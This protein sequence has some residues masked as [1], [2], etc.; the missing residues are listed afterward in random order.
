MLPHR[1]NLVVA[2]A[3]ASFCLPALAE[4]EENGSVS[5]V[6]QA[7]FRP[8]ATM[9][10]FQLALSERG[11]D[12]EQVEKSL[13][14]K[15]EAFRKA[16]LAAKATPGSIRIDTVRLAGGLRAVG[17]LLPQ[18]Q[19]SGKA[20][21]Q[22]QKPVQMPRQKVPTPGTP[23]AVQE[24]PRPASAERREPRITLQTQITVDW[25][26]QATTAAKLLVEADGIVRQVYGQTLPII[27]QKKSDTLPPVAD[28]P[29]EEPFAAN[30]SLPNPNQGANNQAANGPFD[31]DDSSNAD[32]YAPTYV[33]VGVVSS[34]QLHEMYGKAF[35][36][37]T[38]DAKARAG[39][40]GLAIGRLSFVDI[41]RS[42]SYGESEPF[43]S[44]STPAPVLPGSIYPPTGMGGAVAVERAG[45]VEVTNYDPSSLQYSV[46]VNVSFRLQPSRQRAAESK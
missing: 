1:I 22:Y 11:D 39:V 10:R 26:L 2:C 6:G 44:S 4:N 3:L 41:S 38:A 45:A 31:S 43:G 40:A 16:L 13:L 19:Q 37:A 20:R 15:C 5:G 14:G 24:P 7:A 34:E 35:K 27:P 32:A 25:P 21:W 42:R 12:M 33:F 28:G 17:S 30:N 18:Y 36:D 8:N 9:L 23:P 29:P 46:S